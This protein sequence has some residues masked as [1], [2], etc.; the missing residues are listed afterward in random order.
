[1]NN[2]QKGLAAISIFLVLFSGGWYANE[3]NKRT[4][5]EKGLDGPNSVNVQQLDNHIVPTTGPFQPRE[6]IRIG[7]RVPNRAE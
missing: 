5:H 6:Y 2:K 1:M 3:F 4:I 7:N